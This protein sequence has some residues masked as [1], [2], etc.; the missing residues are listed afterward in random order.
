MQQSKHSAAV[1]YLCD[2]PF[3]RLSKSRKVSEADRKLTSLNIYPEL[4]YAALV[5]LSVRVWHSG[6]VALIV[7]SVVLLLVL[8]LSLTNTRTQLL[9]NVLTRPLTVVTAVYAVVLAVHFNSV[10]YLASAVFGAL[11]VAGVPYVLFQV[12]SG[13]WIG[14][15]DVKIGIA[16]GLL[17]GWKYGLLCLGLM[18]VLTLLSFAT[19]YIA[20][21][22]SKAGHFSRIGTGTLWAIAITICVFFE[23]VSILDLS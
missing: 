5:Y 15:G 13:R 10:S 4:I 3:L 11:I 8:A 18:I 20:G 23:P 21:K 6:V 1:D 9:P 12:S 14:G 7:W 16:A 19:E 2:V 17:L 22:L